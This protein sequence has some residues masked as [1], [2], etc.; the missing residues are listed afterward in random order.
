MRGGMT[1]LEPSRLI[2]DAD[3]LE[4]VQLQLTNSTISQTIPFYSLLLS[5][6]N[7]TVN[8]LSLDIE[9]A[10]Y[11]VNSTLRFSVVTLESQMSVS[12]SV[13]HQ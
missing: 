13:H 4:D 7:P 6:D 5:V 10:E 1:G 11:Q 12:P 3:N 9:G 2:A 8:L